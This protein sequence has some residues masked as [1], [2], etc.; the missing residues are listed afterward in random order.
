[1]GTRQFLLKNV[2]RVSSEVFGLRI[3][4]KVLKINVSEVGEALPSSL[5]FQKDTLFLRGDKSEYI[6]DQ[7]GPLIKYQFPTAVVKTISNAGHWLHAENPVEFF[8]NVRVFI[9]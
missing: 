5:N 1:M 3:N 9:T 2:Y 4:L 6:S 7:D 8:H